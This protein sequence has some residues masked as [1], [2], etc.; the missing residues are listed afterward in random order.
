MNPLETIKL[1]KEFPSQHELQLVSQS[2]NLRIHPVGPWVLTQEDVLLELAN[3]RYLNRRFFPKQFPFSVE[4]M[5]NYILNYSI[6]M[7]DR[8]FFII[9]DD[10][11]KPLGHLGL[12]E[13]QGNSA[14]VD[15]VMRNPNVT[16]F[17][18]RD[19]LA[20]LLDWSN[21]ELGIQNFGL[22]VMPDNQ[23]AIDLYLSLGFEF[24]DSE[25]KEEKPTDELL[26][27][28]K[29]ILPLRML[30]TENQNGVFP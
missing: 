9:F 17:F 24:L 23:R 6:G 29:K 2:T 12:S 10:N 20:F 19:V 7:K 30:R 5:R 3:W 18:M 13:I 16:N 14:D 4:S 22:T 1:M 11:R 25:P 8:L 21:L 15:N 28:P 27:T 26:A